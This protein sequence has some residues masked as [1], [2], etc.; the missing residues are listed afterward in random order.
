MAFKLGS[1]VTQAK[2]DAEVSTSPHE[3][4]AGGPA[5]TLQAD[6]VLVAIGAPSV[7]PRS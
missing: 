4:A 1:K 3:P 2:T 6:Y 5:Q 7:Y